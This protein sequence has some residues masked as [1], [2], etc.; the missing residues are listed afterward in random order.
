MEE[1]L[2]LILKKLERIEKHLLDVKDESILEFLNDNKREDFIGVNINMIYEVYKNVTKGNATRRELN[3]AIKK[4]FNLR[5][6]HTTK[7]KQNIYYWGE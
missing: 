4:M 1:R 2:D 3:N 5:L 6:K 7:N